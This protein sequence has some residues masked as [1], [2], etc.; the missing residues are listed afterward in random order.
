MIGLGDEYPGEH[1]ISHQA[2]VED[3]PGKTIKKERSDNVMSIANVV[4][5]QHYVTF[6]EALKRVT[7]I[8]EWEFL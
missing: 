2:M 3:A 7:Q 5:R 6:L 8:D 4:E 1:E